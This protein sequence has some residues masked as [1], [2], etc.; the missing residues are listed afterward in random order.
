MK[1][2]LPI[3]L[4]F[5]AEE[6]VEIADDVQTESEQQ[7]DE[8]QEEVEVIDDE[9]VQND[10]DE[11][12]ESGTGESEEEVDEEEI[13]EEK[14]VPLKA[15]QAEREKWKTRVNDPVTKKKIEIADRIAKLSNADVDSLYAQLEQLQTQQLI[16]QGMDPVL[17]Q[18]YAKDQTRLAQYEH[19]IK[20]KERN[21]ELKELTSETFYQDA[22]LFRDELFDYAER[23]NLSLRDAY[24]V[25]RGPERMKEIERQ[26]EQRVINNQKKKL[27]TKVDVKPSGA[28]KPKPKIQ[29]TKDELDVAKEM[30]LTAQEFYNLKKAASYDDY[31]KLKKG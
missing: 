17:A 2:L 30:G 28:N 8:P 26:T 24:M 9:E 29:L 22:E 19:S 14:M 3:N 12:E 1:K 11:G 23:H 7:P 4:Q 21:L 10:E 6:E 15:L 5:F 13:E 27:K 16:N 20:E 31:L 18:S 25:I